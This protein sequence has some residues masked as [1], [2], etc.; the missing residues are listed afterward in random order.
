MNTAKALHGAKPL[1]DIRF[2]FS[3]ESPGGASREEMA[4]IRR[5]LRKALQG[6]GGVVL[7]PEFPCQIH[8][9]V[10]DDKT[11][12][13]LNKAFRGIDRATDALS[14]PQFSAHETRPFWRNEPPECWTGPREDEASAA[15]AAGQTAS[16]RRKAARR[17]SVSGNDAEYAPSLLSLLPQANAAAESAARR[18]A[19]PELLGDIVLSLPTIK[20]QALRNKLSASEEL[21]FAA[22]HSMLH[23]LGCDHDT[24][25]RHHAMW[26]LGSVL[27]MA[28][29]AGRI[30][31]PARKQGKDAK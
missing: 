24:P 10:T 4:D 30:P 2:D 21:A 19:E 13:R 6:A 14:F 3:E 1:V 22:I 25:A 9:L 18:P 16:G 23:L 12:R 5:G 29:A 27:L 8:V 31:K 20:R 17:G 7:A 15:S 11:I 26:Q 28:F